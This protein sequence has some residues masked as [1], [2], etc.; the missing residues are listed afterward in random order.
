MPWDLF[1]QYLD[2]R[3]AAKALM[4]QEAT[5]RKWSCRGTGPIKP[6]KING[7]LAWP[8]DEIAALLTPSDSSAK[9]GS[10]GG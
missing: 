5:L 6:H 2:T 9:G 3:D 8:A 10:N 4:R 1:P 7:R